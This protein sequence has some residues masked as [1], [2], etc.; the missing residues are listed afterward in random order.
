VADAYAAKPCRE[1]DETA[2]WLPPPEPFVAMHYHFGMLL[3]VADLEAEQ[4]YH[5][6][7][8]RL[9]NAWLHGSGVVWGYTPSFDPPSGEIRVGPGLALDGAGRELLLDADACANVG[10][11][12]DDYVKSGKQPALDPNSFDVQLVARARTCFARPVPAI[13]EPCSGATRATAFSR[14][15]ERV[16]LF[17]RPVPQTVGTAA[18][19]FH[20]VRL[21]LGLDEPKTDANG[22]VAADQE[23]LKELAG[24]GQRGRGA[25]PHQGRSP[26]EDSRRM[27]GERPG[28]RFHSSLDPLAHGRDPGTAPRPRA[29]TG[30]RPARRRGRARR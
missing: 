19:S 23:V 30:R 18:R 15:A 6:G 9:H 12:F 4:A 14:I 25:G 7:K 26:G 20:R 17:L 11:W 2:G 29:S 24:V 3:G 13:A 10:V 27:E 5:R 1:K 22:I 21:F 28:D 8:M 16:E